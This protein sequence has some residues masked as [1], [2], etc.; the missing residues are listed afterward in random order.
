[1]HIHRYT[2]HVCARISRANCLKP[3]FLCFGGSRVILDH[4]GKKKL[5]KKILLEFFF[6]RNQKIAKKKNM[7]NVVQ[8][9]SRY[10]GRRSVVFTGGDGDTSYL[11]PVL[12]KSISLPYETKI[13]L[14][15]PPKR[16][17]FSCFLKPR[18]IDGPMN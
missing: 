13:Q 14:Y 18:E 3:F 15:T 5:D 9:P 2:V 4:F 11:D 8:T 6:G 7:K 17:I 16:T 1:M 10:H 12:G